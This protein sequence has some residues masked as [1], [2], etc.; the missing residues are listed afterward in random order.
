L[1]LRNKKNFRAMV[2]SAPTSTHNLKVVGS[3]PTPATNF[4]R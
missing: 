1:K 4:A 2:R 3:N